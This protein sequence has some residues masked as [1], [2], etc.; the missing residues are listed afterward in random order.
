MLIHDKG[1]VKE[2]NAIRFYL[3]MMEKYEKQNT[4]LV[5]LVNQRVNEC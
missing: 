5:T 2:I 1:L 3:L 4:N